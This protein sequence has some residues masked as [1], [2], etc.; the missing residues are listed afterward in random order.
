MSVCV[1]VGV[2][3]A[4]DAYAIVDVFVYICA[5]M[6]VCISTFTHAC[7][8]AQMR[9]HLEASI[10][11]S[12]ASVSSSP[13]VGSSAAETCADPPRLGGSGRAGVEQ[14]RAGASLGCL[15]NGSSQSTGKG[16]DPR[17]CDA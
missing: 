10:V 6:L 9:E 3:V 13:M 14:M 17:G 5:Y 7:S 12:H 1:V 11:N 16:G 8:Y 15:G 2:R 4:K